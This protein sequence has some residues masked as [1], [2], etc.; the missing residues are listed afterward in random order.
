MAETPATSQ[1]ELFRLLVSQLSEFVIV[2]L[3][4]NGHFTSWHP[5]VK[6]GFEYEAEEFIGEHLDLLLPA[7]D[8]QKGISE[9]E[10]ETAAKEGRTSDTRWL[11][12]KSGQQ[13]LVEGVTVGLRD[14]TGNLAGFGKVVRDVTER[15]KAE[16][17]LRALAEALDESTV[18]IH[19][20]DGLICALDRRM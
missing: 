4:T 6:Q 19:S 14:P 18:F 10:L 3:D 2:L 20:W 5:G 1:S 8:R 17:Q 7:P 11:A 13:I 16:E 9:R 15:K 12:K